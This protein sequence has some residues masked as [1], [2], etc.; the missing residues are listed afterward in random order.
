MEKAKEEIQCRGDGE[1]KGGDLASRRWREQR[2]RF[3]VEVMER[4]NKKIQF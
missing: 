3:S 2:R 4:A 1:S